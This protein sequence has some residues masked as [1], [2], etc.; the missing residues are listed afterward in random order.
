MIIFFNQ[1]T[2]GLGL[3][4]LPIFINAQK[5]EL[6]AVGASGGTS[7][8]NA[9]TL[10]WTLGEFCV[11]SHST[12]HYSW[13]EGFQQAWLPLSVPTHEA[14]VPAD[15]SLQVYPNPTA[16]YLTIESDQE[17][18]VQLYDLLG[19]TVTPS[20]RVPLSTSLNISHLPPGLY[21]LHAFDKKGRPL[22]TAKVQKMN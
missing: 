15:F 17:I 22:G 18:T 5:I 9:G 4:I 8:T 14:P 10:D 2:I 21:L 20:T 19:R 1:M 6:Q 11:T 13:V 16:N 12:N 3:M 7:A